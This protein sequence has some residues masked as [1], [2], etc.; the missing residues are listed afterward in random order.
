[1]LVDRSGL[2]KAIEEEKGNWIRSVLVHLGLEP[3]KFENFSRP[4]LVAQYLEDNK[5]DITEYV[6]LDAVKVE[7][8]NE[9]VGE[10]LG[11]AKISLREDEEDE[12]LYY[13]V[14]LEFWSVIDEEEKV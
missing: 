7:Y 10:W 6:E 9:L 11:P 8:R 2:R 14:I 5:I 13:E 3:E 12:S 4:D 1:M